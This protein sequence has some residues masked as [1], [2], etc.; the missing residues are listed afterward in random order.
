MPHRQRGGRLTF[1]SLEQAEGFLRMHQVHQAKL[2]IYDTQLD[3][4]DDNWYEIIIKF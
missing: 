2:R 3:E 1:A 4:Y